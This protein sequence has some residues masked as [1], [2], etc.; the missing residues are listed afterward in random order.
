M[1]AAEP[2]VKVAAGLARPLIIGT[3]V[4][5]SAIGLATTLYIGGRLPASSQA[6]IDSLAVTRRIAFAVWMI[7]ALTLPTIFV[8]ALLVR[9]NM[10]EHRELYNAYFAT[11][12]DWLFRRALIA[13]VLFFG[14]VL[15]GCVL[16]IRLGERVDAN[17]IVR[18]GVTVVPFSQVSGITQYRRVH[19]PVG[20]VERPGVVI[21][22]ASGETWTYDPEPGLT[23]PTPDAVATF[24]ASRAGVS[25]VSRDFRP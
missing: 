11:K 15:C 20:V 22:F 8:G 17:G 19:A 23:Q 12:Y 10:G 18:H 21:T 3:I 5:W 1:A 2:L 24:I 14:F 9:G 13:E 16:A 6:I 25:P 4:I 7:G